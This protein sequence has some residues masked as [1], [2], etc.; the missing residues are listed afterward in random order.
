[1]NFARRDDGFTLLEMI[2]ALVVLGLL[3]AGLAQAV[4]FGLS[5]YQG[6]S[7]K[8]ARSDQLAT[9]DRALRRLIDDAISGQRSG[10]A[11]HLYLITRL[12]DSVRTADRTIDAQIFV[13]RR[14]DLVLAWTPHEFGQNLRPATSPRRHILLHD[15]ADIK[16]SYW[17]QATAFAAPQWHDTGPAG[18]LPS[19]IRLRI[20]LAGQVP[21]LLPDLVAA[22]ALAPLTPRPADAP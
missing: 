6:Q 16:L 12:P 3:L 10:T 1:M 17:F 22:P 7:A 15:V 20:D 9:T 18:G 8:L 13:D 19:L 11:D 14:H 4:R 2:V 5:A 21:R